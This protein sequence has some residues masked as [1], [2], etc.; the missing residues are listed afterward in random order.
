MEIAS[1]SFETL[2]LVPFVIIFHSNS[3]FRGFNSSIL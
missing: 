1:S 2:N 3:N